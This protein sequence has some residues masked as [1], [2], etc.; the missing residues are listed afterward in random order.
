MKDM[1]TVIMQLI[2]NSGDARSSAMGAIDSAKAGSIPKARKQ[3]KKAADALTKA[4]QS[5]TKIIQEEAK[6]N[7]KSVS[8][9][10][11]HAQDHLMNA[12]TVIDMARDFVDLYELLYE[13]TA[14]KR[15]PRRKRQPQSALQGT[16]K[17]TTAVQKT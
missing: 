4:H 7:I 5:Q 3:L 13:K 11:A 8:I 14:T 10:L 6:G 12:I 15:T 9:L 1:Q 17:R 16:K 2:I